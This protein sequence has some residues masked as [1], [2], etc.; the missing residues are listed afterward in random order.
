MTEEEAP[1]A[2]VLTDVAPGPDLW[3]LTPYYSKNSV[4]IADY[5]N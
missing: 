4:T 3:G 5:N 1:L 2:A